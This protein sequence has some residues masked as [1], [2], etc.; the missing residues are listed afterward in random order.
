MAQSPSDT[1]S[2]ASEPRA[3]SQAGEGGALVF[4]WTG[5]GGIA[6]HFGLFA[7]VSFVVHA[8]G[9]YLFQ[10]VYPVTGRVE[11]VPSR[12]QLLDPAQPSVAG[13]MRQIDDRLVFLRPASSGSGV[14]VDLN[15]YTVQFRPSFAERPIGFRTGAQ[16]PE[17]P[18]ATSTA[19]V[20][21][22]AAPV[23]AP[24]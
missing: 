10:V 24:R 15:D 18:A 8:L 23:P 3:P 7:A 1:G 22:P 5:K 14:R 4:D 17:P 12:V 2:H 19:P 6:A 11:P 16:A 9:F 13:L 20:A 21:P